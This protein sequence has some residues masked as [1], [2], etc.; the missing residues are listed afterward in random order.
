M[1]KE[2]KN[3]EPQQQDG[4][5][6]RKLLIMLGLGTAG[7]ASKA[8]AGGPPFSPIPAFILDRILTEEEERERK[9][10]AA[11]KAATTNKDGNGPAQSNQSNN[12]AAASKKIKI[13]VDF[14]GSP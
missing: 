2:S 1:N 12:K 11:A 4:L 7:V 3:P 14:E 5:T 9:E 10:A 6:R 13:E 8:T